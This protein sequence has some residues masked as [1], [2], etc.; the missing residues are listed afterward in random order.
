MSLFLVSPV[1]VVLGML[2]GGFLMAAVV[3]GSVGFVWRNLLCCPL[4]LIVGLGLGVIFDVL[5][6]AVVGAVLAVSPVVGLVLCL[7][8]VCRRKRREE[9]RYPRWFA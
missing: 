4:V 2:A 9:F 6:L 7:V 3:L 5:L 1:I 8:K